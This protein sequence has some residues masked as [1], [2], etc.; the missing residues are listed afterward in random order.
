MLELAEKLGLSVETV[1]SLKK[2]YSKEKEKI[3]QY[4]KK[5]R[6][7]DFYCLKGKSYLFILAVVLCVAKELK[8]KYDSLGIDEKIY[9]DTMSDI[10]IWC[11]KIGGRGIKNYPWLKNHLSFELFRIGRLQFQ[12]YECKNKT[13]LYKN[14]PFS[15]G[16]KLIY[17]HIPEG[18]SL[19]KE[20]CEKSLYEATEFFKRY[21]PDYEYRF[22]FCESWLLF[23]NNR[24]FMSEKSNIIDFMSLFNIRY[25]L[26]IDS[27]AIERIFVKR[28][29]LK[30][31]YPEETSL[32][33]KAKNYML[34]GNRLGIG[35]GVIESE[36]YKR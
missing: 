27:Q 36:K 13:L 24:A 11:D 17:I 26:K 20:K 32:Q 25:S 34:S 28:R 19:D 12:L 35:V 31:N 1:N 29:L 6:T 30:R 5:C 2:L 23:E 10:K 3:E 14:L 4:A 16:E 15:Y 18:E 7:K 33:K 9:Y 21:F 8:E 22:F